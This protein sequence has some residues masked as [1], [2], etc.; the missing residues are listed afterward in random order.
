VILKVKSIF[1]DKKET[2]AL[3]H[4]KKKKKKKKPKK[5]KKNFLTFIFSQEVGIKSQE[6]LH[7]VQF[8]TSDLSRSTLSREN[9]FSGT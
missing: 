3:R 2:K 1:G 8:L 7:D 4:Y 9:A 5:K 6:T